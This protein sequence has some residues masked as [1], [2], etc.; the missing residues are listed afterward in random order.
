MD[1]GVYSRPS[2]NLPEPRYVLFELSRKCSLSGVEG[3][4]FKMTRFDSVQQAVIFILP[5]AIY[6]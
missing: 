5:L 2:K 3:R 4:I 1:L 6:I